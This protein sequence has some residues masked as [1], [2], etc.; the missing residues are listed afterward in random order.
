MRYY[1]L[2]AS[3]DMCTMEKGNIG[4][5]HNGS[6]QNVQITSICRYFANYIRYVVT[7]E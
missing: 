3:Q 2:F 7:H 1:R 5:L 6:R 4:T